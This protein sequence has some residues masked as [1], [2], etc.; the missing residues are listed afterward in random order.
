[1]ATANR[2]LWSTRR[3][4]VTN[5]GIL[6]VMVLGNRLKPLRNGMRIDRPNVLPVAAHRLLASFGVEELSQ[7]GGERLASP[8]PAGLLFV[9]P[10]F[11]KIAQWVRPLLCYL[12]G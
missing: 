1:M 4:R 3:E 11:E 9:T 7:R 10:L 8:L 12:A 5:F 6:T 2:N